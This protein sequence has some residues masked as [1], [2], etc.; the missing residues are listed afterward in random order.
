MPQ[1]TEEKFSQVQHFPASYLWPARAA[2]SWGK[3]KQLW[4]YLNFAQLLR[5]GG[6]TNATPSTQALIMWFNQPYR[7]KQK[8]IAFF[9]TRLSFITMSRTEKVQSEL[10][11]VT[12][13]NC[14]TVECHLF[15]L[16]CRYKKLRENDTGMSNLL[17]STIYYHDYLNNLWSL[18][19]GLFF[20]AFPT[21]DDFHHSSSNLLLSHQKDC[22]SDHFLLSL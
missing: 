17:N 15:N 21:E 18:S 22:F 12:V 1:S 14:R 19:V 13:H 11:T 6:I 4:T 7:R 8:G 2:S 3:E 10:K 20:L 9:P 5:E 16:Q